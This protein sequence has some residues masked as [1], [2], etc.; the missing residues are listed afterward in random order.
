MRIQSI[1][2]QAGVDLTRDVLAYKRKSLR[3]KIRVVTGLL[4]TQSS[5][6][7]ANAYSIFMINGQVWQPAV[8]L[9]A[10][11]A[12]LAV[13]HGFLKYQVDSLKLLR[14]GMTA[15]IQT[16][17]IMG[18][19]RKRIVDLSSIEVSDSSSALMFRVNDGKSSSFFYQMPFVAEKYDTAALQF[20]FKRVI[21]VQSIDQPD[22]SSSSSSTSEGKSS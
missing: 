4:L 8:A 18:N 10:C 16:Y 21:P 6:W 22:S 1:I 11:G 7:M 17:N 20:L 3:W 15:E 19:P 9:G 13:S 12:L 2:K 5:M 14:G